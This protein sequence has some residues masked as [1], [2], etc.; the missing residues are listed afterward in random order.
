MA[1]LAQAEWGWSM[2]VF[3][4]LLTGQEEVLWG[5]WSAE[6]RCVFQVGGVEVQFPF[7]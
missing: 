5:G 7:F 4:D 6:L 1:F 2:A 3:T